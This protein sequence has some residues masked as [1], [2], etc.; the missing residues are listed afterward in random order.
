MVRC[1]SLSSSGEYT[2]RP[3]RTAWVEPLK[4]GAEN[5]DLRQGGE[6]PQIVNQ[7]DGRPYPKRHQ[8][9]KVETSV[10]FHFNEQERPP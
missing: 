9:A 7:W 10:L 5:P 6:V 4:L 3:C 1:V 2:Q 8:S